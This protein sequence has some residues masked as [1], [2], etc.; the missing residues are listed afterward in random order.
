MAPGK[1]CPVAAAHAWSAHHSAWG[2][3]GCLV[4][5]SQGASVELAAAPVGTK[6]VRLC[7][8]WGSQPREK[9]I[10]LRGRVLRYL[11]NLTGLWFLQRS[12]GEFI[13]RC[14]RASFRPNAAT[15]LH[16]QQEALKGML[17]CL[18]VLPLTQYSH[19]RMRPDKGSPSVLRTTKQINSLP[20]PFPLKN[21]TFI[22][23]FMYS[24]IYWGM[25]VGGHLPRC[26]CGDQ[27]TAWRTQFYPSSA[28]VLD[29]ELRSPGLVANASTHRVILPPSWPRLFSR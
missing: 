13:V 4:A 12:A 1:L 14:L 20:P 24:F 22:Y 9:K 29:S 18:P 28:W 6:P 27:R 8:E 3:H 11:K 16:G 2:T 26:V 5:F 19:D 25:G 15:L 7:G 23:L 10:R 17:F 21:K